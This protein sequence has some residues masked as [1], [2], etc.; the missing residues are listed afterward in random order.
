GLERKTLGLV[1]GLGQTLWKVY[2]AEI[3]DRDIVDFLGR[4]LEKKRKRIVVLA[5]GLHDEPGG[6]FACWRAARGDILTVVHTPMDPVQRAVR[7][8][9]ALRKECAALKS[10]GGPGKMPMAFDMF[11]EQIRQL[12]ANP[13]LVPAGRSRGRRAA[14]G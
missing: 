8:A 6:E 14:A 11:S 12:I 4:F 10:A 5:V 13:P 1:N 7:P 2:G 3:L 9:Y